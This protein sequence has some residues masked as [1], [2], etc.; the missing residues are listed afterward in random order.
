MKNALVCV[1]VLVDGFLPSTFENGTPPSK[2]RG[3]RKT[4]QE[5]MRKLTNRFSDFEKDDGKRKALFAALDEAGV[6]VPK[7]GKTGKLRAH[8][9]SELQKG[10]TAYKAVMGCLC[11]DYFDRKKSD[12]P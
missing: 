10:T 1:L 12:L 6:P 5:I 3:W 7:N 9:Y 4:K 11:R 2:Q 8:T